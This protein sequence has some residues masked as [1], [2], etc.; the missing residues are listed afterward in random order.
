MAPGKT[1]TIIENEAR[2]RPDGGELAP[3]TGTIKKI[4]L[5]AGGPGSFRL[6]IAQVKRSTLFGTNE[7][8][9]VRNGPV[10]HYSGQTEANFD[11]SNFKVESFNVSVPIHKGQ[12]LAIKTT[13]T[14]ALYCAG[15]GNNILTYSSALTPGGNYRRRPRPTAATCCS[16]PPSSNPR[17]VSDIG[18]P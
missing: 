13:A 2:Y 11:E 7:A 17:A 5:V 18:V 10:I 14:S 4:R 1:C 15:G 12:Y 6:Q 16:A 9:V 3:K 8:K